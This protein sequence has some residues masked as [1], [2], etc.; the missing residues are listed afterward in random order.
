[1]FLMMFC[2]LMV[3]AE[4][5]ISNTGVFQPLAAD[6]VV[7]RP[8]GAFYV[9]NF[10]D[11]QVRYFSAEGELLKEIGRKG[12]GPGE[13]TYPVDIY[14]ADN[15]LYVFD[16]LT[17]QVSRFNKEG[18]Y[19]DSVKVPGRGLELVRVK[20]GWVY[21]DWGDFFGTDSPTV[22]WTDEQFKEKK[23]LL[24]LDD[25]G[26]GKGSWVMSD[27]SKTTATYSPIENRPIIA[28]SP[29]GSRVYVTSI[30]SFKIDVFDAI[31]GKKINTIK[32]DEPRIPFD[33]EW[34]E[35]KFLETNAES[36]K[37]HKY[38]KN[39]PEY[40][41]PFRELI[42]SYDGSLIIDRWRGRPDKNH[43]AVALSP[44]GKELKLNHD[45]ETFDRIAGVH[46]EH[47]YV[48]IFNADDEE[49]GVAKCALAK[50]D[51]FIKANPIEFDGSSGYSISISN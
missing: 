48:L 41:P 28:T 9:K 26:W 30:K 45:Y 37:K 23:A 42:V 3:D 49:A 33:E 51:A 27:G 8:D 36:R 2:M 10:N 16:V 31:S 12:K 15:H 47:A 32:R 19:V 18:E 14:F 21:G 25:A 22:F 17:I 44:D 46:K 34:A 29:D 13:F 11:S 1:M 7:V 35:E 43:H 39:Y 50:V 6:E 20:N 40:F 5:Q 4:W 24:K 38:K